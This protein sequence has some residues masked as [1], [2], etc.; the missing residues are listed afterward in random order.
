M[1]RYP[2]LF[3]S[4]VPLHIVQRGHDRK[5]VFV[6]PSDY[7]YYL[8][9]LREV[10]EEL[11][12]RVVAYCLMTNHVHLVLV[13]GTEPSAVSKLMRVIAARQTRHVNKLESRSGTLWEGRFK[14]SLIDT[15]EYLL[16][17]CRYI[18]LNPVRASMVAAPGDYEW[19]GYRSRCGLADT[20]ILDEHS[21][22]TTLGTSTTDR[23]TAYRRFVDK[24]VD[25]GE[26]SLIRQAVQRNQ[27]T[28]GALFKTDIEN[29]IG[30]R[31]STKAPGRP[32]KLDRK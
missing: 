16:A 2:R 22:F 12:I 26:L 11:A 15:S 9:N 10:K 6:Q 14:A 17:C 1:P 27:L 28:G 18:D 25:D 29:R 4:D 19:S 5:P 32:R 30:R 21:M 3:I 8:D 31:L 7:Q 20:S 13:P 24:G 23:A